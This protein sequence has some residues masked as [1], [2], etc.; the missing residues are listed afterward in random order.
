[1]LD[2]A[3]L[4]EVMKAAA[5]GAFMNQGQIGM[6]T[7]RLVVD[8]TIADTFVAKLGATTCSL[9]AGDLRT[10]GMPLGAVIGHE[11]AQR[12][13]G[14]TDDAVAKGVTLAAGGRIDET[15]SQAIMLDQVT[16]PMRIYGE[17][18]FG[19]IV[20]VIRVRGIEEALRVAN[21]TEQGLAAAVFGRDIG[22]AMAV[23]KRVESGICDINAPTVHDEAQMPFGGVKVSGYGRFGGKMA[24]DEV[25]ELRWITIRTMPHYPF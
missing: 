14:L 15:I 23:A 8:E 5:F 18:W 20:G 24:I 13:R 16:P 17:E 19:P 9:D 12:I 3:D 25:T 1:M 7:E 2:D 22:R 4:D 10:A 6:S 11:A 21:D